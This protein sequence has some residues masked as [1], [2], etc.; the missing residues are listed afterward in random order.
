MNYFTGAVSFIAD[1]SNWSGSAGIAARLGEHLW[2][3]ALA[4]GIA[5]LIALPLGLWL[6][7]TGKGASGVIAA[8]GA[9]RAMPSLGLLTWLTLEI[10]FGIRLPVVPSTIVL[11]I[12]AVPPVLAATVSGVSTVSR[13]IVDAAR[14]MGHNERQIITRVELPLAAPTIVGGVRS[15]VLQVLATATISAYIGLG[16]LGRYLLDGLA[17][18]DYEQMLVGAVLVSVLA[19]AADVTLARVQHRLRPKGVTS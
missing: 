3:S 6:G 4:V 2:Y 10:S 7:H 16:G 18:R 19:L 8:T 17:L 13:P 11:L 5:V 12:L 1:P 15:C 9:L 14:A